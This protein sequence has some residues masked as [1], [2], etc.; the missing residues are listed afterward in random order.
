[1]KVLDDKFSIKGDENLSAA[2]LQKKI[3]SDIKQVINDQSM[4]WNVIREIE[5]LK[6]KKRNLDS[7]IDN[8]DVF[9]ERNK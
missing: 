1:M 7:T 2:G 6:R 3:K 9:I 8:S 5:D 4:S